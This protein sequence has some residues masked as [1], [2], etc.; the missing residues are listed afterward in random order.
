MK[1]FTLPD[2]FDLNNRIY[3]H[4]EGMVQF[5]EGTKEAKIASAGWHSWMEQS[6]TDDV[7]SM[8]MDHHHRHMISSV[9][10][11]FDDLTRY[12]SDIPILRTRGDVILKSSFA[13]QKTEV[14]PYP[15]IA[16]GRTWFKECENNMD[17]KSVDSITMEI[18]LTCDKTTHLSLGKV[19]IPI[20]SVDRFEIREVHSECG[21]ST[22]CYVIDKNTSKLYIQSVTVNALLFS[23]HPSFVA[24]LEK[25]NKEA[26][27]CYKVAIERYRKEDRSLQFFI[28]RNNWLE[29]LDLN[30]ERLSTT[31]R[32]ESVKR[33]A[34]TVE[35]NEEDESEMEDGD[36]E[37]D[38]VIVHLK[39]KSKSSHVSR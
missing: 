19:V 31:M 29:I 33:S 17:W 27:H 36:E 4:I 3:L 7:T 18:H 15:E 35:E 20:V 2:P 28:K 6:I 37:Q 12:E 16:F 22:V 34:K 23:S 1:T 25:L 26:L 39:K 24:Y 9:S 21:R 13:K 38:T 10:E 11:N 8:F 14:D 5:R 30:I 32:K